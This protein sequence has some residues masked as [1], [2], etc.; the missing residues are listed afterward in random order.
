MTPKAYVRK[1]GISGSEFGRRMKISKHTA[2]RLINGSQNASPR[3]ARRIQ[4]KTKGEI[5]VR[6]LRPDLAAVFGETLIVNGPVAEN[7]TDVNG[8]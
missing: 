6:D 2:C 5:T 3:L 8:T 4:S 1:H 7:A